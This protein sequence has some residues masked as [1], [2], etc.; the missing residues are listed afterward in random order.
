[1]SVEHSGDRHT[2]IVAMEAAFL[3]SAADRCDHGLPV[4]EIDTL[5][6][7]GRSGGVIGSRPSVPTKLWEAIVRVHRREHRVV[8]RID[9]RLIRYRS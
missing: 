5:W 3:C 1:M 4:A 7:T 6:N 8:D 2:D 9:R